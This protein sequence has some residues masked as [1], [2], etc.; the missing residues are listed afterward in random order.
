MPL[1]SLALGPVGVTR[2]MHENTGRGGAKERTAGEGGGKKIN[3]T[4]GETD[5]WL[6]AR[7]SSQCERDTTA[8]CSAVLVNL[9]LIPA[10]LTNCAALC[11]IWPNM[12]LW[13]G[14][15]GN[16]AHMQAVSRYVKM[17]SW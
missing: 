5:A 16:M 1:S 10:L 9:P 4:R 3:K 15:K 14:K 8:D 7:L 17:S 13:S 12:L 6:C 11:E 2:K